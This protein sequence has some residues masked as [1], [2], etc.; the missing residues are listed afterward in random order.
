M[1]Q[2]KFTRNLIILSGF[3]VLLCLASCKLDPVKSAEEWKEE[4]RLT[5]QS[6]LDRNDTIDFELQTSGLYYSDIKTGSGLP[7]EV[8]DTVEIVYV[9]M[10]LNGTVFD[11]NAGIDTSEYIVNETFIAGFNEGLMNMQEGGRALFLIPSN[12]AF[13]AA[14]IIYRGNIGE[15]VIQGYTPLLFDVEIIELRKY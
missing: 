11:F 2:K 15:F 8:L 5:I 14:G 10:F 13:G 9:A 3:M 4:E 7:V 1:M 6:F 12:L